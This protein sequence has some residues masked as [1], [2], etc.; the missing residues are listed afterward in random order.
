MATAAQET[1]KDPRPRYQPGE[2]GNIKN[3]RPDRRYKL[4][5]PNDDLHGLAMH[6][7]TGWEKVSAKSD[8]ERIIG[9]RE[10]ANGSV[11]YQGQVLLWLPTDE[12]EAREQ[13]KR[14]RINAREQK[15]ATPAGEF[16][17]HDADGKPAIDGRIDDKE[18]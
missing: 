17:L 9:G 3:G 10:E 16:G 5:N 18:T 2:V 11:T 15:R 6:I 7:D 12:Y 8:K 13:E 14:D 1:R 4:A